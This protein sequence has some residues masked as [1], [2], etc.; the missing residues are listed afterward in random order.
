[1]KILYR[2]AEDHNAEEMDEF[3]SEIGIMKSISRHP[4]IVSLIGYCTVTQ[5]MLMVMEY[6]GCGDLVNVQ[7]IKLLLMTNSCIFQLNYLRRLRE[8]H[9]LRAAAATRLTNRMRVSN[10]TCSTLMSQNSNMSA[11]TNSI[12]SKTEYSNR[13]SVTSLN[14]PISVTTLDKVEQEVNY[15]ELCHSS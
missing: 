12:D 3:L 5:P 14:I 2:F 9:E 6:V 15:L 13:T 7:E 1:M 11:K 10:G 4:N 8:Q